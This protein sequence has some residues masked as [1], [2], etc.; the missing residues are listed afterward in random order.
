MPT[1]Q[2]YDKSQVD[3]LIASAGGLPDPTSASAGDVLTLDSNKDPAWVAP[4]GGGGLSKI[5][6]STWLELKNYIIAHPNAL[7]IGV[8]KYNG[9]IRFN[10]PFHVTTAGTSV[11]LYAQYNSITS[12]NTVLYSFSIGSFADNA[13]TISGRFGGT[14]IYYDGS[15]SEY[16]ATAGVLTNFDISDIY[17]IA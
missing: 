8:G 16:S 4:S 5:T 1:I 9:A 15:R 13:N 17:A 12:T 10:G 7:I 3:A 6:F 14:T 2:I 11:T